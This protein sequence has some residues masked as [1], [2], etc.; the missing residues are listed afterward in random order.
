MS[1]TPKT[2]ARQI[3]VAREVRAERVRVARVAPR[4]RLAYSTTT[5]V[6][7]PAAQ[8]PMEVWDNVEEDDPHCFV[9][10]RHTDHFAEHDDLVEQGFARYESDGTVTWTQAG[11]EEYKA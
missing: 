2:M 6:T 8:V 11:W 9:C 4:T 10:G 3:T 7:S 5:G 1:V